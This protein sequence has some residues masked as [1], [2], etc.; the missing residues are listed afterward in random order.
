MARVPVNAPIVMPA[1]APLDGCRELGN[2]GAFVFCVI[3]DVPGMDDVGAPVAIDDVLVALLQNEAFG[4]RP[5]AIIRVC[6]QCRALISRCKCCLEGTQVG[7]RRRGDDGG[8]G[9]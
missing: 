8:G 3:G 1:M 4:A 6:E 9:G 2:A 5:R 7:R